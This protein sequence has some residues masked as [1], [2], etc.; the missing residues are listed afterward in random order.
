MDGFVL[1]DAE[2]G[3]GQCAEPAPLCEAVPVVV[4]VQQLLASV[5][6][7]A[8]LEDR[9]EARDGVIL[10]RLGQ[11]RQLALGALDRGQCFLSHSEQLVELFEVYRGWASR[12]YSSWYPAAA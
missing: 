2:L 5:P 11:L 9:R 8:A 3:D 6:V 7:L 10:E 1:I 12:P 4:A